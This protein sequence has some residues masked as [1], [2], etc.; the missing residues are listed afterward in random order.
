MESN[1]LLRLPNLYN[2]MNEFMFLIRNRNDHR[3]NLSPEQ[4]Q[5]FLKKCEAYITQLKEKGQLIAAQPIERQGKIIYKYGGEFKSMAFDELREIWVGY[6]HIL[7][8][9]LQEAIA[10]AKENPE[11]EFGAN[12]T[13][14][15]RPVK[16]REESTGFLYPGTVH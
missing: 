8:N 13:I 4:H 1:P 3:A 10:I 16:T 6:Y 15:V 2:P 14:E 12:A 7:A 9:D 5:L 11:F